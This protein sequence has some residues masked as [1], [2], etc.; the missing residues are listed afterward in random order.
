MQKVQ[1][2]LFGKAA[3]VDADQ[4]KKHVEKQLLVARVKEINAMIEAEADGICKQL[5]R[6]EA[7]L[8][9]SRIIRLNRTIRKN[10]QFV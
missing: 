2:T 10:V 1:I 5:L 7:V 8:L 4:V 3:L 6:D 9:A